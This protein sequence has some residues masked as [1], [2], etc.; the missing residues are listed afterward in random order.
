MALASPA[1][2]YVYLHRRASDQLPFYVGKG[3]G[4]RAW[5]K[6]GRNRYW[7]LI[8]EK[9][10]HDVTIVRED[11]SEPCAL[12]LERVGISILRG[13]GAELANQVDGGG[14]ISGWHHSAE[15]KARIGAASKVRVLTPK[16]LAALRARDG[17]PISEEHRRKLSAAKKGKP[18]AT[19]HSEETRRKI[20]AS[21]MGM[22]PSAE[23]LRRLSESH[24][25]KF[26]GRL[27]PSYDHTVRSFA[28]PDH[29][30]FTGT[31][32][33]FILAYSL[34]D[35]DVSAVIH[36]RQKSVKGWRLS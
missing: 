14:G 6:N 31:R 30:T 8:A 11:L 17:M 26:M 29:G 15:A 4:R 19:P 35:G 23:T 7:R 36:G 16:T 5:D 21:H 18:K 1:R 27:S 10:G 13:R 12:A 33:D 22:R 3:K 32:A 28:H 9:H 24:K 25:G 2:H 34:A 20:S